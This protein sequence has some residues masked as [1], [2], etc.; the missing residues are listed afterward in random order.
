MSGDGG[1]LYHGLNFAAYGGNLFRGGGRKSNPL[2]VGGVQSGSKAGTEQCAKYS[3]GYLRDNGYIANGNAWNQ[4]G[5][6][7]VFS[8]Y[9][10]LERP[11]VFDKTAVEAYNSAASDNVWNNFDSK[12]LDPDTTY[13]VNMYYKGSPYLEEA[14]NN[15]TKG[16]TGTHTGY[17]KYE[18]G[19]W[20]VVHNIHGKVHVDRFKSI[21]GG[22]KKYGVTGIYAP[23]TNNVFN[24]FI[25]KLGFANGGKVNRFDGLEGD[26]HIETAGNQLPYSRTFETA[27]D[28]SAY[29]NYLRETGQDAGTMFEGNNLSDELSYIN[30]LPVDERGIF[31]GP[32]ITYHA[33]D[34][35]S[36]RSYVDVLADYKKNRRLNQWHWTGDQDYY[37]KMA[38][39]EAQ[40]PYS[41]DAIGPLTMW[42]GTKLDETNLP[43]WDMA[44]RSYFDKDF[45]KRMLEVGMRS[46]GGDFTRL[47]DRV[48]STI[49]QRIHGNP[50]Y[51]KPY[52]YI[53]TGHKIGGNYNIFPWSDRDSYTGI[54]PFGFPGTNGVT[55]IN[56]ENDMVGTFLGMGQ[57]DSRIAEKIPEDIAQDVI[58][59]NTDYGRFS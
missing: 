51:L 52:V 7:V 20:Y 44:I 46:S 10:G 18:N 16:R 12:T 53:N 34:P 2:S 58:Y 4:G 24:R 50:D 32:S 45:E 27:R 57:L 8:G 47:A 29:L 30:S 39:F 41:N 17:L 23:R 1:Q 19:D 14:Y 9:D 54:I 33:A 6:T 42:L 28:A 25:T 21:Q 55:G 43:E 37:D 56:P 22:N 49:Q 59:K 40:R 3:N 38:M 5:S 15:G 36:D 48:P 11:A 31:A 35:F 26:S 13:T